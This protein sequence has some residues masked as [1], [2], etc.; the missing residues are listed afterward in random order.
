MITIYHKT[1]C[2]TSN[3]VL[4]LIKQSGKPFK[5][6]EY[7]KTPLSASEIRALLAKLGL[8]AEDIIRKKEP[9]FKDKY[10]E[11]QLSEE[12]YIQLLVENPNFME[13]PI[14]VKRTQGIVGRPYDKVEKWI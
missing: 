4:N 3:K 2:S 5:I 6:V 8:K 13:R 10:A 9:L 12:E 11:K 7:V 14:L 1:T